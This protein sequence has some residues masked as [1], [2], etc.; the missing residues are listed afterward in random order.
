MAQKFNLNVFSYDIEELE[1][2]LSLEKPYS[3][4]HLYQSCDALRKELFADESQ[5]EN[6]KAAL[7]GFLKQVKIKL[8]RNCEEVPESSQ[9][10]IIPKIDK[11]DKMLVSPDVSVL[12]TDEYKTDEFVPTYPAENAAKNINPLKKRLIR[13]TLNIDTRFRDNYYTTESTDIMVNLP[14]VIKNAV[15]MRLCGFE[16]PPCPIYT[17]DKKYGNNF[18]HISTDLVSSPNPTWHPITIGDGNYNME[19]MVQ[20]INNQIAANAILN[21]GNMQVV[22]D[23]NKPT[24]KIIFNFPFVDPEDCGLAFNLDRSSPYT[25]PNIVKNNNVSLQWKLGWILGFTIAEYRMSAG[26]P[27]GS[28]VFMGEAPYDGAGAKYLYLVVDDFNNNVNNYF[29][30]AFNSSILNQNILARL[31]Q[32]TRNDEGNQQSDAVSEM[33]IAERNYFGPIHIQKLKIQLIDEFGRVVSLNKRDY[34]I[35]LEFNCIYN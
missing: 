7:N 21:G 8:M 31:P 5:T 17:I 3:K 30:G 13:K 9:D 35:A 15:S 12:N 26:G 22:A 11:A 2:L 1:D 29:V 25:A 27:A 4:N 16:L 6:D 24:C 23:V 33:T 28:G 34:S 10:L 18:F 20:A 19:E 14:T 32:Y